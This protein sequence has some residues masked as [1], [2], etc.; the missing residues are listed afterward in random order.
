MSGNFTTKD[1]ATEDLTL[2]FTERF[3]SKV[4]KSG[5]C[6]L[7]T[8]TRLPKG[9]GKIAVKKKMK[10]AHRVSWMLANGRIP[11]GMLVLHNCPGGD[12][13]Q[14]VNPAHLFLGNHRTNA[15]DMV[16][17]GRARHGCLLGES[18][19][20]SRLTAAKVRSMF[21]RAAKGESQRSI[22]KALGVA[23]CT[24]NNILCGRSWRHLGPS[25]AA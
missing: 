10:L 7:W 2:E 21:E 25:E 1:P 22:G 16:S 18:H 4:D 15:S 3:W 13:P 14:C 12:N 9:Y 11:D 20:G 8:A 23:K 5:E 19:P 6:W 17:K 24:V